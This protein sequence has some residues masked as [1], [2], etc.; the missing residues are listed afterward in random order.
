MGRNSAAREDD[1]EGSSCRRCRHRRRHR[2]RRIKK[3]VES[4]TDESHRSRMDDDSEAA[5]KKTKSQ[6]QKDERLVS[7]FLQFSVKNG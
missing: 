6:R 5:P 1:S 3:E 2:E 4:Q 7:V